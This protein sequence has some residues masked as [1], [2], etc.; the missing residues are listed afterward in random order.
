M[1]FLFQPP[2]DQYC[3]YATMLDG[4]APLNDFVNSVLSSRHSSTCP[5]VA[6]TAWYSLVSPLHSKD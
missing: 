3:E 1:L 4:P 5:L 2:E 6:Q